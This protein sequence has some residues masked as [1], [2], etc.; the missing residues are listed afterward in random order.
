MLPYPHITLRGRAPQTVM[1]EKSARAPTTSPAKRWSLVF[2]KCVQN[3]FYKSP[4]KLRQLECVK[5]H[6]L[7]SPSFSCL[8]P[9]LC[10]K[11]Y[12]RVFSSQ[13]KKAT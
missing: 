4:Q 7:P 10:H 9:I 3:G 11:P 2:V 8:Q 12:T 6:H 13:K 1:A 5:F